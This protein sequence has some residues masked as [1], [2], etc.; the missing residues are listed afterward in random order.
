MEKEC[1]NILDVEGRWKLAFAYC[2]YLMHT[3]VSVL[4]THT[5]QDNHVRDRRQLAGVGTFC[6][7]GPRNQ[8]QDSRLGTKFFTH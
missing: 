7:V 5:P 1:G 3:A 4:H 2:P 8:T 6:H